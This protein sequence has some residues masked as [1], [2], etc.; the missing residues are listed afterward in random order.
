MHHAKIGGFAEDSERRNKE[1]REKCTLET[2]AATAVTVLLFRS[3][4][5]SAPLD[6][7]LTDG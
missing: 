1:K 4:S 2:T 6:Y 7:A 5:F 3:E